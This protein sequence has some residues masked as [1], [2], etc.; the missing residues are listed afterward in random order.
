MFFASGL[1]VGARAL[2]GGQLPRHMEA[3][4]RVRA[5]LG[6]VTLSLVGSGLCTLSSLTPQ[7]YQ[8]NWAS[9]GVWGG[10]E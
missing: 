4:L 6:K 7:L 8:Y 3:G 9:T 2:L 1:K 10:G 5:D